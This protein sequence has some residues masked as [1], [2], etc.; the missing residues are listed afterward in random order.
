[1]MHRLGQRLVFTSL[2]VV[3]AGPRV[4]I[5][6]DDPVVRAR[7]HFL[8]G[9]RHYAAQQY[10][11]AINSFKAAGDLRASPILD[12]NIAHC[13][14]K[15]GR[16]AEAVKYYKEYISKRPDA[17][18]I[19]QVLAKVERLEK[20]VQKDIYEDLDASV[21]TAT[22]PDSL[23]VAASQPSTNGAPALPIA[24]KPTVAG[25][26]TRS[27][28]D[29]PP[30]ELSR[31]PREKDAVR[32]GLPPIRGHARPGP[33]SRRPVPYPAPR[34]EPP[35]YTQWWFWTS[36]AVVGAL[37]A[38]IVVSSIPSKGTASASSSGLTISF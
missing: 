21:P 11:A 32:D 6:A 23:P 14:E 3:F 7:A 34:Q 38:V 12:S 2:L 36:I 27:S 33:R 8:D 4:A 28:L 13:F 5:A 16:Y 22:P 17:P 26:T 18:N 24:P 31:T 25:P 19:K 20:L 37:A 30:R 29:P 15:L 1:M 10:F 9:K 35:V